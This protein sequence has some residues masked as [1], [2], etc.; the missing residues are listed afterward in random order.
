[1][2]RRCWQSARAAMATTTTAA[3]AAVAAAA[4]TDAKAAM[5]ALHVELQD[6]PILRRED[7]VAQY[8]GALPGDVVRVTKAH[9]VVHWLGVR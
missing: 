8:H 7:A 6:M 1:M 2:W 9:G 3:A 4:A 5:A